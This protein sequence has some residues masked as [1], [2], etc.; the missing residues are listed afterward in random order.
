MKIAAGKNFARF[1]KHQRIVGGAAG[2]NFDNV[3][4]VRQ[5]VTNRAVDL[6]HAAQA[7]A[8]CTRGSFSRCDC[9]NLT[10]AQ[11]LAQVR[12]YFDLPAMRTRRV[13]AFIESDRRSF[14]SFE[15]HRAGNIC[16]AR[17]L[18]CAMQRQSADGSH[19]LRSVQ[20]RECLL[21]L[22][23]AAARCPRV[24]KRRRSTCVRS[25]IK[26]FALANRGQR[27]MRQRR[28]IAARAH[29]SFFGNH[30]RDT[31]FKHREQA[32]RRRIG[33]TAAVA[34]RQHVRAQQQHRARFVNRQRIAETARMTAHEIQLQLANLRRLDANVGQ[35]CRSPCSRHR[36]CDFRR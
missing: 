26:R 6:R 30:R 12:R 34:E 13:N 28:E 3:A 18:F 2:F 5:R 19:R 11:Q 32:S 33:A 23:V 36:P 20:Q 16:E 10:V 22:R 31:A 29:R 15:R 17:Q 21:W 25:S 7:Y 1:G 27:E 9:A 35:V 4:R 8:S 14:Q 24:A